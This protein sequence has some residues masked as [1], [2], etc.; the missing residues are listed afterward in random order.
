M[1]L[2]RIYNK[3]IND[4][5]LSFTELM[6]RL[7]R[8][9]NDDYGHG[10]AGLFEGA[11]LSYVLFG[12]E[13]DALFSYPELTEL[14][15]QTKLRLDKERKVHLERISTPELP[16]YDVMLQPVSEE[17]D[18]SEKPDVLEGILIDPN[19][20]VNRSN[21]SD[22]ERRFISDV[23]DMRELVGGKLNLIYAPTG[24]G[25][26][27]FVET[28]LKRYSECF[29]QELLYLVPTRSLS[30]AI[31][32]RGRKRT[33]RYENGAVAE[34][35]EQDGMRVMTYAAFGYAIQ[36][37]RQEGTYQPERWWSKGALIC[38]DELSQGVH[39]AYYEKGMNPTMFA[40]RELVKRTRDESNTVVTLSA[41]P[42]PAV[43]YFKFWNN[44][45][46]NIVKSTLGL[47]GYETKTITG[48][49]DLDSLLMSL[50]DTQRGLIFISTIERIISAVSLLEGR[51]IH[52]V[53]IW[54]TKNKDHPLNEEQQE[55]IRSLVSDE[56]LPEDIQVLIMNTAYE[57]GLNIRPEKSRLDYIVV[58]NSN[59]DTV[60]QV[61]GRYRGDLDTLYRRV[62]P[63]GCEEFIRPVDDSL[64]APFL[65]MRL[66][67]NDKRMLMEAL[68]F[69]D[70]RGRLIGW[71]KVARH[72]RD[73]GYLV[74]DKKSGGTRYWMILRGADQ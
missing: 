48:Y 40:L 71:T 23:I 43:N 67:K 51:G 70:D 31:K 26:T 15:G 4:Y 13:P 44:V 47:H 54:S 16:S 72:I 11:A 74:L 19:S 60:T 55:A 39:Q 17:S 65:G 12:E 30:E 45:D 58:H 62:K 38:L 56:K 3:V 7:V 59:D 69:R 25:K 32:R 68:N 21:G 42:K 18:K 14:W 20:F 64:I 41:T 37:E 46:I 6:H 1:M 61:R 9:L 73:N 35:W 24:T 52:A 53:G 57:T 2:D 5:T 50:D 63:D 36:Y 28:A 49:I 27:T 34:W 8:L 22:G 10:K 29:S 66:G 33:K